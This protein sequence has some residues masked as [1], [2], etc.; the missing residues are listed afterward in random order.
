MIREW[1][2]PVDEIDRDCIHQ[3]EKLFGIKFRSYED[4]SEIDSWIEDMI[5][6]YDTK[7]ELID[8]YL[9]IEYDVRNFLGLPI[10]M[11]KKKAASI[12]STMLYEHKC[13]SAYIDF[14]CEQDKERAQ[15]WT[16]KKEALELAIKYL[17]RK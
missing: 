12:L 14:D 11:T 15:E 16:E 10:K 13:Q 4:Y 8:E 1:L 17:G 3:W 5:L 6:D 2:R 7:A 9:N